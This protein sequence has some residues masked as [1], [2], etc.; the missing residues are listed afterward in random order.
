MSIVSLRHTG[1]G[2]A[3]LVVGE[4]L[5]ELYTWTFFFGQSLIPAMNGLL[6]GSLLYQS[7]LVPRWLP[8]LAFIGATLLA[9]GWCAVFLG[10]MS[11][12]GPLAALSAVPIAV[13]EFSLGIYLTFWGFK[14]TAL[15]PAPEVAVADEPSFSDPAAQV[16]AGA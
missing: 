15:T 14:E 13:W 4:G 8:M 16:G 12:M 10:V 2:A 9:A 5:A 7:R 6:L 3:A 1:A 11:P